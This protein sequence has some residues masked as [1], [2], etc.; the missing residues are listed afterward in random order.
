M[1]AIRS[2]SFV[3]NAIDQYPLSPIG[4]IGQLNL[5]YDS[6]IGNGIA[7]SIEFILRIF[8][9]RLK[10]IKINFKK[11]TLLVHSVHSVQYCPMDIAMSI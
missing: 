4:S 10:T 6:K 11:M 8:K 5:Q 1:K 2:H 7:N 9:L 3:L